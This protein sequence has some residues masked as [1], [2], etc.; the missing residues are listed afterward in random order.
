MGRLLWLKAFDRVSVRSAYEGEAGCLNGR[1][2]RFSVQGEV[3]PDGEGETPAEV[4]TT[5]SLNGFKKSFQQ[6]ALR[7]VEAIAREVFEHCIWYFLRPGGAPNITVADDDGAVSLNSLMH[8][9]VYSDM[10]RTSIE[11]KGER[12]EMVSLR[13]KSS[14]RNL[15]PRLYWCAANRVVVEEN[16]TSKVLGVLITSVVN[17]GEA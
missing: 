1:H 2:F 17:A 7:T 8:D 14:Q 10:Q 15:A 12:F 5:V 11:V 4:G 16:L 6:S 3:E 13:L 9:F